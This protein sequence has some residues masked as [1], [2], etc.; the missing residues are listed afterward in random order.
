MMMV[1]DLICQ[2]L[3]Y[4]LTRSF[5]D[6]FHPVQDLRY[7]ESGCSTTHMGQSRL[8]SSCAG[9]VMFWFSGSVT[10]KLGV[11]N[12]LFLSLLCAGVR[13]SL[14]KRMDHPYYVYLVDFIRGATFGAFWSSS[15]L[16]ASKIGPPSLRS[17]VLLLL[18]GI[19][20]GIGRSTGAIIAGRLQAA[21]GT[22]NLFEYCARI[23]Y[24]LALV[25]GIWYN[26]TRKTNLIGEDS[27]G[28]TKK[29]N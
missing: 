7:Q 28:G 4:N 6:H 29:T 15:T 21:F 23:N 2:I 25:M 17:S 5:D 9:G 24:A 27:S 13:F 11:Q 16:Y 14:L 12:V 19:Y 3:Q 18:N 20:N 1:H 8:L 26:R 22:N 10:R